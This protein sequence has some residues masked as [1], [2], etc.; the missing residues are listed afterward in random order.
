MVFWELPNIKKP[1]E[2]ETLCAIGLIIICNKSEYKTVHMSHLF[3]KNFRIISSYQ[4]SVIVLV[5]DSHSEK[6]MKK[7]TILSNPFFAVY[8]WIRHM[9]YQNLR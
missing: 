7:Y 8:P 2:T 5:P 1:F 6:H 9:I 4:S 3:G